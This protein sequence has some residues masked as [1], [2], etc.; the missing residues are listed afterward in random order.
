MRT[1][2]DVFVRGE[3]LLNFISGI[4][5]TELHFVGQAGRGRGSE[6]GKLSLDWNENF[7]MG[8][9]G[10]L[11]SRPV[12]R[13][14]AP[15][16][17][18]CL[19]N[20]L[21]SHEDVEVGR[22]VAFATGRPCTWAYEMQTL[23]YHSA[24][25][26]D[27]RGVEIDPQKIVQRILSN[28]ITIHPIKSPQNMESLGM[29]LKSKH[30]VRLLS[31][32]QDLSFKNSVTHSSNNS[33]NSSLLAT[34]NSNVFDNLDELP[35]SGENWSFI[36]NHYLHTTRVG[37]PRTKIPGHLYQGILQVVGHVLDTINLD[38]R[39]RGR[40]IEFRDLYYVYV[41]DDP[42]FGMTYILDLLL[43]YKKFKGSKVT[44]KVRR[45]LYVRQPLLEPVIKA[46]S[47]EEFITPSGKQVTLFVTK[48][49]IFLFPS[50]LIIR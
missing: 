40:S 9:T 18:T 5:R 50:Y 1:D 27:E 47:P 35:P 16:I 23:F 12:L 19:E 3:K 2:D 13:L 11:M 20:L 10:M 42:R 31:V 24:G 25:G 45:H 33:F 37:G 44:M 17:P 22:C 14:L 46:A 48:E 41:N 26:A 36:Y 43:V 49:D 28:A 30:R 29:R 7:C 39:E 21:T 15:K 8:G 32:M 38:A 4:N 6:E 34:G